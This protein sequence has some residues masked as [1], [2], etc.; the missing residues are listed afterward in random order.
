MT[1]SYTRCNSCDG[2][3]GDSL[4]VRFTKACDNNCSFCIE[5]NGV[6]PMKQN[7]NRMIM[8][9]IASLKENILILGGEPCLDI[10]SLKYY[11]D[12]IRESVDKIYVTTSLPKTITENWEDFC[13][14]MNHITGLNVSLQ[15]WNPLLNNKILNATSDHNRIKI[16]ATICENEDFANKV[17]V[18]VNLTKD[19]IH[20]RGGIIDFINVMATC[21]VKSIKINE[22]Q[23]APDQYI[24]YED[25]MRIKLPSPY[26]HGCQTPIPNP[27][28]ANVNLILKRSCFAVEPSRKASFEDLI[29]VIRKKMG[30]HHTATQM[31][32]YENGD[33][34]K[35]WK[36]NHG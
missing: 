7:I 23:N 17:R 1:P 14:I 3:Y 4:D 16:L 28:E 22:L 5:K 21:N 13:W 12:M 34:S 31:V 25:I 10:K 6:Q 15:H 8:S 9:T 19:G 33:L 35:G 30:S 20:T 18:N 27:C 26:S 11:I 24:S 36:T 2:I 32:L 29:K